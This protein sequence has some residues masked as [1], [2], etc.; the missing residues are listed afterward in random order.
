MSDSIDNIK[1]VKLTIRIND[2]LKR[3]LKSY[4]GQEKLTMNEFVVDSIIEKFDR[5]FEE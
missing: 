3:F 4:C 5:I 2:E 1:D